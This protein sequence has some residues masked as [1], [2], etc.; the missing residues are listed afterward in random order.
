MLIMV[1]PNGAMY[2]IHVHILAFV[3]DQP[4]NNML[5]SFI[6]KECTCI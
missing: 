1:H 6:S 2:Y 5:I 3:V 4:A